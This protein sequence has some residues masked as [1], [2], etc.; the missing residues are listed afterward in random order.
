[1]ACRGLSLPSLSSSENAGRSSDSA[2]LVCSSPDFETIVPL[3]GSCA[4]PCLSQW[5]NAGWSTPVVHLGSGRGSPRTLPILV[6]PIIEVFRDRAADEII[7]GFISCSS[8]ELIIETL[9]ALRNANAVGSRVDQILAR[10]WPLRLALGV[11]LL[12]RLGF[13]T[14][15]LKVSIEDYGQHQHEAPKALEHETAVRNASPIDHWAN[16]ASRIASD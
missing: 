16:L 3:D 2:A 5:V 7:V 15:D 1:M 10:R 4:A 14:S 8:V 6:K 13:R 12:S 11:T 9:V